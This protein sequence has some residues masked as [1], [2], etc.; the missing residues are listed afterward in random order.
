MAVGRAVGRTLGLSYGKRGLE[1]AG[2][3]Y[4]AIEVNVYSQEDPD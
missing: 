2:E 1:K 4:Q 3:A